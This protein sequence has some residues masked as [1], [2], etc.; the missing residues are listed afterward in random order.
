MN[1]QFINEDQT[2]SFLDQFLSGN[3]VEEQV[4][5]GEEQKDAVENL[6]KEEEEKEEVTKE[7]IDLQEL[8]KEEV[9]EEVKKVPTPSELFDKLVEEGLAYPYEDGSK[10][11]SFEEIADIVKQSKNATIEHEV[12]NAWK[13]KIESLTPQIQTIIKYAESGVTS[14]TELNKLMS[15]VSHFEK[16]SELDPTVEADQE[17]IVF[18]QL[19]NTGLNEK[20]AK[21]QIQVLK[22]SKLLERTATQVQPILKKTYEAQVR[23]TFAEQQQREQ[24]IQRYVQDNA[25]NVQSFIE[26]EST[27][28]P[29]KLSKTHKLA[30]LD[31]AAKPLGID[32]NYEPV[33]GYANYLKQLQNGTE[34]QYK[35]FMDT[36]AFIAD[37][38][39]YKEKFKTE[40][41]NKTNKE[42]FKK[43][44]IPEGKVNNQEEQQEQQGITLQKRSNSPW[45]I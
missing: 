6:L 19:L 24:E 39:S 45:S 17:Q 44:A 3:K 13:Q 41:S 14:V 1:T 27:F 30:I 34:E 40:V 10:P 4:K 29:F 16:V 38:K 7:K 2:S 32:D 11:E 33:F 23:N 15:E 9:K 35:D 20:E 37:K 42:N 26:N 8:V 28:I 18:L 25:I 12:S 21:D 5:E 36:I 22:D 43:I 31:L